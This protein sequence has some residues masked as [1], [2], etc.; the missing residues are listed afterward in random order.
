MSGARRLVVA[1]HPFSS[2]R[3]LHA[4]SSALN[5]TILDQS[6]TFIYSPDREGSSDSTWQSAWSGSSDSTYDSTHVQNNIPSGTSSHFTTV[7][8]ATVDIDFMGVAVSLYGQGTAG[9]YT[10][11]IDGKNAVTGNPSGSMLATY[12]GLTDAKHTITLTATKSQTLSLSYATIT[13]RSDVAT[14]SVTNN[15][16]VAVT[17]SG[18]TSTTNSFFS[19]TGSGFSNQ[20]SDDG[21]TRL[22]SNSPG[23]TVSFSCSNT[24][25]LYIYGT[26]NYNHQTF[27][28]QLDPPAGVSQGARIFN[29]TSKWFVLDN[30]L[31]WEAGMD[32]TQTY[33]VKFT[34]LINGSYSDVHSVVMM[35]LPAN[36]QTSGSASAPKSTTTSTTATTKKS[37][38]LGKTVGIAVGLVVVLGVVALCAFLA[39]SRRRKRRNTM[40]VPIDGVV[41]PFSDASHHKQGSMSGSEIPMSLSQHHPPFGG[42]DYSTFGPS[43]EYGETNSS[44]GQNHPNPLAHSMYG[45]TSDA[46]GGMYS[47]AYTNSAANSVHDLGARGAGGTPYSESDDYSYPEPRRMFAAGTSTVANPSVLGGPSSR[48]RSGTDGSQAGTATT[49][50]P[51]ATRRPEKGPIPSDTASSRPVRQEVDAGRVADAEEEEEILPPNYDPT[52]AS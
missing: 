42:N 50:Q 38:S 36:A 52:W 47:A 51:P 48:P 46:Y 5:I 34:N 43:S 49:S 6:P 1:Y 45:G 3:L 8:G 41:T 35:N 40:R 29:G 26:T 2:C 15:T 17:A 4:M 23:A 21:Y 13:I 22:D 24:S 39:W 44:W 19:T 30:L 14:N 12:G 7:A 9:A 16:Q 20:H 31:F 27:S 28:V 10:T 32:P 37:S 11:T 18:A 25:A 33:Q